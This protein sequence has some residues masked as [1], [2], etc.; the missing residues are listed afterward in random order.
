MVLQ[1]TEDEAL[2]R[3]QLLEKQRELLYLQ[4]KQM[5]LELEQ[6]R[7]KLAESAVFNQRPIEPTPPV[8]I[9]HLSYSYRWCSVCICSIVGVI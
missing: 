1:V 4:Q 6:A 7:K 2:L 3:A 5:D 9:V 8:V